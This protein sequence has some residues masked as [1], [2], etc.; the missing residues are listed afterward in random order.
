MSTT[1]AGGHDQSRDARLI[2]T[3]LATLGL[4]LAYRQAADKPVLASATL[5]VVLLLGGA[6]LWLRARTRD[7]LA[8][9]HDPPRTGLVIGTIKGDWL[10]AARRPYTLTWDSFRQHILITGPTGRGKSYGFISPILKASLRRPRTGVLYLDGKGDP[11]PLDTQFDHTFDP[12]NPSG[13]AHWNPLAADDPIAGARSFADALYP[14]ASQPDAVFYE[15][16]GAFAIRAVAPAIAYTG[17][18]L[19]APP[20][21]SEQEVRAALIAS[22][23]AANDA[24]HVIEQQGLGACEDQLRW[25]PTRER[26]DPDALLRYITANNRP[27]PKIDEQLLMPKAGNATVAALHHVLFT[28]GKLK[29]LATL[30]EGHLDQNAPDIAR[31]RLA[32]LAS[33]V[34]SLSTMPAKERAGILANLENRL[35]VFLQP[36]FDRLCNTTDFHLNDICNGASVALL[37]PTGTYPGIAEPLGRT[38]LAQFQHAVLQ[39]DPAITKVAVLDEFHNFVSPAFTKF[40]SQARSRGGAAVMS[41]QTIAD[42]HPDYRDRLLANASTQILTPGALPFDADHF[43]KAFGEEPTPQ[44]STS[45]QRRTL[46]DPS[47]IAT[48]RTDHRQLPRYT[49][50]QLSE[51]APGEAI[52]RQVSLRTQYPAT[53][54]DVERR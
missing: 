39:S 41:T 54:V 33:Q 21:A 10:L 24:D 43:S 14:T 46:H 42:F 40:L 47:P 16:R 19:P 18:G 3:I 30:L 37:L 50:T 52:I 28:D 22:G 36:P 53:V 1:K 2:A 17:L 20:A 29:E 26:Q 44:R 25:L 32:L 5:A 13:S 49:P 7:L 11:L 8:R 48:I 31:T 34:T 15:V 9:R 51:L 12:S 35:T 38:A 45:I 4:F 23:I 6:V 27:S